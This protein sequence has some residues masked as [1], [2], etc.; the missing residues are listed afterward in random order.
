MISEES[1][2]DYVTKKCFIAT[3]NYV[4]NTNFKTWMFVL[5]RLGSITA[6][7]QS[8]RRNRD[9]WFE[10][11]MDHKEGFVTACGAFEYQDT[12]RCH[13]VLLD[14]LSKVG[15]KPHFA[16][17]VLHFHEGM[18]VDEAAKILNTTRGTICS[19]L[20]R[21]KILARER[22]ADVAEYETRSQ[23]YNERVRVKV[24]VE[25]KEQV[26]EIWYG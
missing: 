8:E 5:I 13:N 14:I 26:R 23:A 10:S 6:A 25:K 12:D 22:L 17:F 4:L 20:S 7:S 9:L 16:A 1:I 24:K 18:S 2:M 3:P 21:F 11:D 15:L 19:R